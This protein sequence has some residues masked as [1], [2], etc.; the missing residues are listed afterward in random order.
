LPEVVAGAAPLCA[1]DDVALWSATLRALLQD[2][3]SAEARAAATRDGARI[4]FGWDRAAAAMCAIY[5]DAF[6]EGA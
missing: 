1:P 3:E 6:A 5:Q 2:R 4:R